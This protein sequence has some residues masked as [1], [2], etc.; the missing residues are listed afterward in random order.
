MLIKW[1][2]GSLTLSV[3]LRRNGKNCVL[4]PV[5]G[6]L[7]PG[8][9]WKNK[10]RKYFTVVSC[11][12]RNGDF[13]IRNPHFFLFSLLKKI[14]YSCI[15]SCRYC[16]SL[17]FVFSVL[18]NIHYVKRGAHFPRA[19]WETGEVWERYNEGKINSKE[20]T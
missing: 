16:K 3:L 2:P 10:N 13:F 5:G 6:N 14:F 11:F 19:K 7:F 17:F 18:H 20:I 12:F 8:K 15:I 9:R 1:L 4:R